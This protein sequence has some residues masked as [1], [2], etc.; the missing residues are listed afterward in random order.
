MQG[1]TW[2]AIVL[3]G[4][5]A[6]ERGQVKKV[7]EGVSLGWLCLFNWLLTIFTFQVEKFFRARR[8]EGRNQLLY[9]HSREPT[10]WVTIRLLYSKGEQDNLILSY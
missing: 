3:S 9:H 6:S 10:D 2:L 1:L 7:A 8:C 4:P 5:L